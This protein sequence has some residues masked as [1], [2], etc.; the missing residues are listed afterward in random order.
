MK[1]S[2]LS[3]I[4]VLILLGSYQ[5]QRNNSAHS[6]YEFFTVPLKEKFNLPLRKIPVELIRAFCEGN[7]V[8]FYPLDTNKA[9]SYHEFIAHFHTGVCQPDPGKNSDEFM[10]SNCPSNFCESNDEELLKNFLLKIELLQWKHFDREKSK[11]VYN[12]KYVK[13]K[14]LTTINDSETYLDGPIFKIRDIN[15]LSKLFP[16][17]YMI[18]NP[19]NAAEN[20]SIRRILET[21]MFT[22]EPNKTNN[23][24]QQNNDNKN[25]EKD[26]YHH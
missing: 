15:E 6:Q 9:C 2:I 19:K 18:P 23:K 26:Y 21:R 14:F 17:K 13:L 10:L 11:E 4:S 20:F 1:K 25:R 22:G 24:R 5:A 16:E 3:I 8:G 12:V 7:I